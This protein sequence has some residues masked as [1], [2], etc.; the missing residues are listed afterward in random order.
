MKNIRGIEKHLAFLS[1]PLAAGRL[2]G[3]ERAR[4]TAEY[5]RAE[6]EA[7]GLQASMQPVSVPAARLGGTPR[8]KIREQAFT[9]RRD[10]AELT[11]LSGSGRA[12]GQLLT[13]SADELLRPE[14]YRGRVVLIPERP[15]GFDLAA[16]VK[17]AG[18]LGVAALLV[19]HGEPEWFHKTVYAGNGKIPVVRVRTSVAERM[20]TM[21]GTWT[22]VDLPIQRENLPCRNVLGWMPGTSSEFTLALTAHY[23]HV[24]DDPGGPRFPGAFDNASGVAAVLTAAETLV[25]RRLPF[26]VLVGF[27]T[28]EESGLW[29]AKRLIAQPP[30]PIMAA[31]NRSTW[32]GWAA[33]QGSMPCGWAMPNAAIG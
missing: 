2:S 12:Q 1:G 28:G 26:N 17:A 18:N 27:L 19:E 16:T 14:S 11:A 31:I 10:F 23:D 7:I 4:R 15:Q 13:V 6:L 21:D 5:L 29:G 3:T 8:L 20:R 32:M 22:E 25:R 24:G 33:N 30:M 9:P